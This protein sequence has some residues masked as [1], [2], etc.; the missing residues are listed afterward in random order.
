MNE[1]DHI[2]VGEKAALGPLRKDLAE[3][4]RQWINDVEVR[5]GLV[6]VGLYAL[7]AEEAWLDDAIAK[8][9]APEPEQANF[10]I[11]DLSDGEAVGTTSL[12]GVSWRSGRAMFGIMV[13][14]RRGRGL[15]TEATRLT[16]DWAFNVLGLRNVMLEVLPDNAGAIRAYEAAGFRR[17]GVRRD[18]VL[19]V[20]GG[21]SDTVLMDAV[22][23]DF[24]SPVLARRS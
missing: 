22:A 12:F 4:Y 2:L 24:V 11:Y 10:T 8:N 17:V 18:S 5:R 16:L 13:G 7:E 14:Q 3:H 20:A 15:G 21:R 19:A 6:N 23:G 1:T 9:A